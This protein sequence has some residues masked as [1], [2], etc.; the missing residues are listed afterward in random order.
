MEPFIVTAG[1]MTAGAYVAVSPQRRVTAAWSVSAPVIVSTMDGL[2]GGKVWGAGSAS[3]EVR[4]SRVPV[5]A[6]RDVSERVTEPGVSGA[7][8]LVEELASDAKTKPLISI[9]AR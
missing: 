4:F 3:C 7:D 2:R 1:R 8:S 5:H 6:V 9:S